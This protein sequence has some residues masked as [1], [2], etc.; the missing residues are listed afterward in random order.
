MM[1]HET[2]SQHFSSNHMERTSM[3]GGAKALFCRNLMEACEAR[4]HGSAQGVDKSIWVVE[5]PIR[6]PK[7]G[8]VNGSR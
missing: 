4:E 3:G 8:G 1:H 7:R 2:P 6:R 5:G